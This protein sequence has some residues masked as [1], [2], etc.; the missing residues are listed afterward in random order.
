VLAGVA[1]DHAAAELRSD[2]LL[3]QLPI[4]SHAAARWRILRRLASAAICLLL[5]WAGLAGVAQAAPPTRAEE[6]LLHDLHKMVEVQQAIGWKIDRYEYE[7]MLPDALLSVCG[8][9]PDVRRTAFARLGRQIDAMGGPVEQAFARNGGDIDELSELVYV[10]R[11]RRLLQIAMERSGSDCPFWLLPDPEFRGLQT[12]AHRFTLTAETGGL[13][14]LHLSEGPPVIGAGGAGRLLFARGFSTRWS[15]LFG[16]EFGGAAL[17]AKTDTGTDLPIHFTAATPVLLRHHRRT[18]HYDFEIA[19]VAF[20]TQADPRP[21]FGGRVGMLLGISSLR[22][23]RIMPWA[24][25]GGAIEYLFASE[26][27]SWRVILKGGA[28]VGFDWDF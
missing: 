13:V 19:P 16:G 5:L 23:R 11:V 6:G 1:D 10:T 28:R 8:V 2:Q 27:R 7:D 18:W 14:M 24:G 20:F 17:L 22:V 12:D 26:V 15:L 3:E 9:A 4:A 21:S 25:L